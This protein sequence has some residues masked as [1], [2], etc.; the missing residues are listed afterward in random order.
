MKKVQKC[1]KGK[2]ENKVTN[3]ANRMEKQENKQ[4]TNQ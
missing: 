1:K 2:I 3:K 4:T